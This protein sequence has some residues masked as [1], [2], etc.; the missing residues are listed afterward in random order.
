MFRCLKGDFGAPIIVDYC[1]LETLTLLQ[2]RG[3]PYLIETL[4]AF[5]RENK[6]TIY[7]VT[8]QVFRD[9]TK[10]VI[11][12]IQDNLSLTDCSIVMVSRELNVE[13][14]GTFDAGLASFFKTSVGEG[15]FDELEDNEKR[16]LLRKR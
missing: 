4:Q 7:F 11:Q 2:Q 15:S 3:L 10:L 12:K 16:L 8:E 5:I 13:T 1:M 9:A 6:I 14:I